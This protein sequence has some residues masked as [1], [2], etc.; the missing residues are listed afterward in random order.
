MCAAYPTTALG[1]HPAQGIVQLAVNFTQHAY[2]NVDDYWIPLVLLH[3]GARPAEIC[4]LRVSDVM[5]QD[6]IACLN[7]TDEGEAQSIKNGNSR[8]LVPIH[9]RLI[10]LG[11]LHY[12]ETHGLEGRTC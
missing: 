12:V 5:T 6:N 7:I 10:A 11:F 2:S 4:Q 8:R 1:A 3:T 9:S